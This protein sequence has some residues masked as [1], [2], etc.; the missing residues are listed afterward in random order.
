VEDGKSK[1]M[2]G[3]LD[4]SVS[5]LGEDVDKHLDKFVVSDYI[6]KEEKEREGEK[7]GEPKKPT[8]FLTERQQKIMEIWSKFN[9]IYCNTV[10]YLHTSAK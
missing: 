9:Y 2:N 10:E 4:F 7:H 8:E 6:Q 1:T 3:M 5:L